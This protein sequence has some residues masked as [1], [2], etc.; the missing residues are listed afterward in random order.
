MENLSLMQSNLLCLC[1][2]LVSVAVALGIAW[3]KVRRDSRKLN[4]DNWYAAILKTLEEGCWLK[5]PEEPLERWR[6]TGVDES[7]G[8]VYLIFYTLSPK[9]GRYEQMATEMWTLEYV[10]SGLY[11]NEIIIV[12][13]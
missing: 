12:E 10:L 13:K 11:N 4:R 9:S 7:A 6:V 1:G 5:S 3:I 2:F 8:E